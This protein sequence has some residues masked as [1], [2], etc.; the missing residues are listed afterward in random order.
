MNDFFKGYIPTKNKKCLM[1]FKDKK[2]SDLLSFNDAEKLSEYGGIL[3]EDCVLVDFD[4]EVMANKAFNI[5][6]NEGV[7]CRVVATNRGYHMFFKNKSN[8]IN[9]CYTHTSLACGL[10][11]DIKVGTRNSYAI[12]KFNDRTREIVYDV[13]DGSYD[14]IPVYFIPMKNKVDF[15]N[16][17]DGDGRNQTLYNHILTL[18]SLGLSKA[19]IR[20]ILQIANEYVFEEPLPASELD[21][22]SR[23][24]AFRQDSFY[25]G[26]S[27]AFDKF[28]HF[29]ISECNIIKLNGQ[30]YV[31]KDGVYVQGNNFIEA[32]MI[33]F[34]PRL[35]KS[36]RTEILEYI[37]LVM[38]S[39]ATPA[40]SNLIAFKN[41]IYDIVKD[42]MLEFDPKYI[43]TNKIEFDYN[44]NAKSELVR[45][46]MKKISCN[47]DEIIMLLYEVAGYCLFRKSELGKSFILTG[48][49]ANGKSTYLDM[50]R[51]MLGAEN[52]SSLDLSE[53]C[54]EFKNST[55]VGKLANIGDDISGDFI[56]DVSVFK[57]LCTGEA[58]TFNE[59]FKNPF[60]SA[61]YAKL[62]FSANEVPRMGKHRDSYAIKR[63]V[64]LVPFKARFTKDDPD[65]RPFIKYELREPENI[66]YFIKM[67][68]EGLRCVLENKEFTTCD[69]VEQEMENYEAE[70]NSV[71][72]FI[73]NG[74]VKIENE[75]VGEVY[76]SYSVY[77][78]ES[79]LQAM[80]KITFSKEIQKQLNLISKTTSVAGR[81]IRIFAKN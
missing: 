24:E 76:L 11:A 68:V 47:N 25:E 10:E 63:R 30:L 32:A 60:Q 77:C 21:T 40:P 12:C 13:N 80:S 23:D 29:L 48:G 51:T 59:K 7:K 6:K 42:E 35:K 37:T 75:S 39:E 26:S 2:S 62:L 50:I 52:V 55:I 74:D 81:S 28:S 15:V 70:N 78:R 19:E 16:M 27:L 57:K 65:Y 45:N 72:S 53:L 66:E 31:Y 33:K 41:G 18:Q 58:L 49:G 38:T 79:N 20:V 69:L 61:T 67:A 73:N 8:K 1:S 34:I 64:V 36:T 22:I 56:P 46:T 5:I 71:T 9:K 43:I 3:S 54:S 14:E 17:N 44:P 4:D